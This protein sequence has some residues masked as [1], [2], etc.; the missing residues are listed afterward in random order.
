MGESVLTPLALLLGLLN[1]HPAE[2][3]SFGT[4]MARK[5][6]MR[7]SALLQIG[8]RV[9]VAPSRVSASRRGGPALN[10]STGTLILRINKALDGD[11]P[12][13]EPVPS[14]EAWP[15]SLRS[16]VIPISPNW[17]GETCHNCGFMTSKET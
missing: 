11:H 15:S 4:G 12:P 6:P 9:S 1:V 8:F 17:R 5:K 3:S 16:A 13:E 14:M 7:A 10:R 2:L